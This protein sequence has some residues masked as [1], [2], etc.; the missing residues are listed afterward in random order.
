MPCAL[1]GSELW[2][3]MSQNDISTVNRLQ[4][5]IVQTIQSFHI[6]TRSDMCESMLGLNRLSSEVEKRKL[7]FLHKI[8]NI[9]TNSISQ[10]LFIRKY[11]MFVSD[12]NSVKLGFIPDVCSLLLK[13]ELNWVYCPIDTFQVIEI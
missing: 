3:G 2:N 6:R 13:Y 7:M 10:K 5:F 8:L 12:F 4:H 9:S 11:V 1:Y